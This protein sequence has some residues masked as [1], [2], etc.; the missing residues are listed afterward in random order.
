MEFLL[1]TDKELGKYFVG[2][3]VS[4]AFRLFNLV[5]LNVDIAQN[6]QNFRNFRTDFHILG[7]FMPF[8]FFSEILE[9]SRRVRLL[10]L[11]FEK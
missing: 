8:F 2:M 4:L 1:E 10:E 5:I 6:L 3:A 11:L 7:H 9:I